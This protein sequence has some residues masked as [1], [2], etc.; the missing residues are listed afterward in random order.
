MINTFIESE[1]Y[2]LTESKCHNVHIGNNKENSMDLT[3]HTHKMHE[4]TKEKY[5]GHLI[6]QTGNQRATIKDRKSKGCGIVREGTKEAPLG[7]WPVES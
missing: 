5:V 3:V 6:D 7:K 2:T 1:K 4:S